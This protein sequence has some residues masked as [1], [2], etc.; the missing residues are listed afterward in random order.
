MRIH[1]AL[2]LALALLAPLAGAQS[3]AHEEGDGIAMVLRDGP[4]GGRAVAGAYAHFGF[5]LLKD[6]AP[7]AH[8]N[9]EIRVVHNGQVLFETTDAHEYD[10]VFSLDLVFPSAGAYEV[11][12][13]SEGMAVG[14]FSGQV[15]APVNET[16]ARVVADISPVEMPLVRGFQAIVSVVDAEGALI[17]HTDAILELREAGS[18]KLVSRAHAHVHDAPIAFTQ[19]P[20]APGDYELSVVAYKAFQTGRSVDVRP[21]LATFPVTVLGLPDGVATPAPAPLVGADPL[22]PIAGS[23]SDGTYVLH[24]GYDPQRLVGVGNPARLSALLVDANGTPVP[25]VDF[26]FA[27]EGPDGPVFASETLHEYDGHFEFTYTPS[28]P[29]VYEGTLVALRDGV[30]IPFLFQMQAA[31]PVAPLDPGAYRVLV[32]GL[33][34]VSAGAPA[35]VVFTVAGPT[36]VLPHS[37]EDVTVSR[38]GEPPVYQF[39]MHTHA[40]GSTLATLVFPGEGEWLVAVDP[41]ALLPQAAIVERAEVL[42]RVAAG[43]LPEPVLPLADEGPRL[44]TPAPALPAVVAAV[45]VAA[46]LA[47]RRR[48]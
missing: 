10:G 46:A 40:S 44:E 26:R 45:G 7:Q 32:E 3:H 4:D 8:R 34:G 14:T 39:K 27:L 48:P 17:P 25:H 5:A 38:P 22:E 23:A 16:V 6:G 33:D 15:V 13:T 30:E 42:V 29:G 41:I 21:V 9:A 19:H 1:A 35:D 18:K 36:G 47:L 12:A 28:L 11:I 31:P 24:G 37:E 2:A 43:A 20:P